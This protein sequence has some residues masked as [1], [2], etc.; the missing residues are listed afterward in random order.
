MNLR[1]IKL[2]IKRE[3][4]EK[5]KSPGFI[6]GTIM[7]VVVIVGLSFLPLLLKAFDQGPTRI[8]LAD[9]H[10]LIYPYIPQSTGTEQPA[11]SLGGT[12]AGPSQS[13]VILFSQAGTTDVSALSERVKKDKLNAFIVVSGVRASDVRLRI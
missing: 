4:M 6:I 11:P 9:P 10:N 2:I 8:A 12:A 5:L 7:G 3:Y 1:H 13:S